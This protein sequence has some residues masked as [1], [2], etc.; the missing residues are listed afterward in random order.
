ME[1]NKSEL[2]A[3]VLDW[4]KL[5]NQIKKNGYLDIKLFEDTFSKTYSL[6]SKCAGTENISKSYVELI[7]SAYLF[8]NN[9]NNN[10]DNKYLA[11]LVLTERMLKS[12]AFSTTESLET[13]SV[14]VLKLRR[15][16]VLNF[17]NIHESIGILET[18]LEEAYW[19]S[20]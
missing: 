11:M 13:S 16:V 15:E 19:G 4:Q 6:L 9:E 5:N 7:A 20:L 8:A 3:L 18:M 10:L 1:I 17:N 2:A 14:Y 12:C